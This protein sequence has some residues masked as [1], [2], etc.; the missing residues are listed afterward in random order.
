MKKKCT[1]PHVTENEIKDWFVSAINKVIS[2]K[3]EIIQNLEMLLD[4]EESSDLE[5]RLVE[6][7]DALVSEIESIEK[8]LLG[9]SPSSERP[10]RIFRDTQSAK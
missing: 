4:V 9:S 10:Q 7:H 5:R 8:Q 6:R 1:S 2:N 3:D